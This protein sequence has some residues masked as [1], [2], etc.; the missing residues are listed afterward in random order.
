[1]KKKKEHSQ[2]VLGVLK[3]L[4]VLGGMNSLCVTVTRLPLCETK[5]SRFLLPIDDNKN[6]SLTAFFLL[7]SSWLPAHCVILSQTK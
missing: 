5:A 4:Q 7:A 3:V 6:K 1:M 2:R